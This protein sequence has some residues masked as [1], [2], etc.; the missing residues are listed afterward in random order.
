MS[1]RILMNK[2]P[3]QFESPLDEDVGKGNIL[4]SLTSASICR[5]IDS[6]Q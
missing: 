4:G 1:P 5:E 3:T 6:N 2:G